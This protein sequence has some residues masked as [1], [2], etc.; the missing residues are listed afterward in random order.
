MQEEEEEKKKKS[1]MHQL[2]LEFGDDIDALRCAPDFL[3]DPARAVSVIADG[4]RVVCGGV[5]VTAS[6]TSDGITNAAAASTSTATATT[7]GKG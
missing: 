2:T 1:Q 3:A 7:M 5:A 6:S 4:L